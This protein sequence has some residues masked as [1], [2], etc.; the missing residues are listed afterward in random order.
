MLTCHML[1][2][3]DGNMF[4]DPH[5]SYLAFHVHQHGYLGNIWD[6]H[7]TSILGVF[8]S[9]AVGEEG[10]IFG[11]RAGLDGK[12]RWG[13]WSM[14]VPSKVRGGDPH[15]HTTTTTREAPGIFFGV[16]EEKFGN[17]SPKCRKLAEFHHK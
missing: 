13:G 8:W 15:Y 14:G 4:C 16:R 9:M 5:V 12:G 10:P 2:K 1:K 11:L 6:P 3:S 7:P 17:F